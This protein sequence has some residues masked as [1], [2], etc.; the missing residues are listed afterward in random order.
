M[1]RAAASSIASPLVNGGFSGTGET[2]SVDWF[3]EAAGGDDDDAAGKSGCEPLDLGACPFVDSVRISGGCAGWFC[4]GTGGWVWA[5]GR[6]LC[7]GRGTASQTKSK[8]NKI[9]APASKNSFI[10]FGSLGGA[11]V[12]GDATVTSARSSDCPRV[13]TSTSAFISVSTG[14]GA[15]ILAS[16]SATRCNPTIWVG[17][18][19]EGRDDRISMTPRTEPWCGRGTTTAERSRKLLAVE[20]RTR[21]SFS[22][23]SQTTTRPV[24]KHS[25][26][27]AESGRSREPTSGASPTLARQMTPH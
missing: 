21:K 9:D 20:R 13:T 22:V 17:L 7:C 16:N 3:K 10:D 23:S 8:S 25:R 2:C 27:N 1:T 26:V 18:N 15:K 12:G 11:I 4:N 24:S 5:E 6:V 14:A 19:A